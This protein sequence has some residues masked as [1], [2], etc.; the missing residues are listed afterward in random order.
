MIRQAKVDDLEQIVALGRDLIERAPYLPEG[1]ELKARRALCQC[2]NS[3]RHAL[4]VAEHEGTIVGFLA[5][6]VTDYWFSDAQFASDIAF[7]VHP[8]HGNYAPYLMRRFVKWAKKF[9][10]VTDVTLAISSGLDQDGR[11]GRMYQ[12]NGFAQSGGMFIQI[13]EST[14][15][16]GS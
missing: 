10:K 13:L 5:G 2:M 7:H 15:E 12:N 11:V 8:Q 4:L 3:K 1:N 9:P 6:C 16:Q 14:D